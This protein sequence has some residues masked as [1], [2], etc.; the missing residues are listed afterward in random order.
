[1]H[2][3]YVRFFRLEVGRAGVGNLWLRV[4]GGIKEDAKVERKEQ[5]L[6]S[7]VQT[8]VESLGRWAS[9]NLR[10]SG[11]SEEFIK[12]AFRTRA[13]SSALDYS[14]GLRRRRH[15]GTKGLAQRLKV[16]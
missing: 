4:M 14:F 13:L 10:E 6:L 11:S 1:M 7:R 3:G 12:N 15:S 16:T 9:G 5:V 8:V 2:L